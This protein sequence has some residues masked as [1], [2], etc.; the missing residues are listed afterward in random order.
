MTIAP[1]RRAALL[2]GIAR[3]VVAL[4]VIA[5][6]LYTYALGVAAGRS[7]LFDYFGY[8]TNLTS[9]LTSSV[10]LV[11][12]FIAVTGHRA[13]RWLT[14]AR[15]LGTTYMLLVGLVYNVLVPGTGTA[16]PWVSVVLHVIFPILV[17]ADWL[18]GPDRHAIPW[19]LLVIVLPYPIV[20]VTVVLVR[21]ATDG[22]VP[23]GFLLPSHGAATLAA[24][25]AAL[26]AVLLV[27]GAAVWS[28]GRRR[29]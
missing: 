21:G 1:D 22:W 18:A 15:A 11:A 28:V 13:P 8:F 4:A 10:L 29:S 23:Y 6:L 25:V 2:V 16:P 19:A 26:L 3:I 14:A 7:S 27:L 24:H 17:V 9:L 12:G 20:R 5:V